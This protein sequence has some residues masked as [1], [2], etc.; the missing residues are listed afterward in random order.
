MVDLKI[1]KE[2]YNLQIYIRV[3]RQIN[4]A[5]NFI[6]EWLGWPMQVPRFCFTHNSKGK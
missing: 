5:Q 3:C 1:N 6:D 4:L 2:Y